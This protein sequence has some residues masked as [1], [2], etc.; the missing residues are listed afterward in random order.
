ME[1]QRSF[2]QPI[3][4][5]SK[6]GLCHISAD[7]KWIDMNIKWII[8]RLQEIIYFSCAHCRNWGTEG[9][10]PVDLR[11]LQTE[12]K[13]VLQRIASCTIRAPCFR[14]VGHSVAQFFSCPLALPQIRI[15]NQKSFLC[16][17][18]HSCVQPPIDSSTNTVLVRNR[19][20]IGQSKT[21]T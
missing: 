21:V 16:N 14:V 2:S 9:L 4:H 5:S 13:R 17:Q 7:V 11:L 10:K 20:S 18:S 3:K 8:G 12:T 15:N 19:S 6:Y 1:R